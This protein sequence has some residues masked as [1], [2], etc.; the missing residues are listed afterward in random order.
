MFIIFAIILSL[1]PCCRMFR[2]VQVR[3]NDN[4]DE[5]DQRGERPRQRESEYG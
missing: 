2:P 5:L 1:N 3:D 4:R